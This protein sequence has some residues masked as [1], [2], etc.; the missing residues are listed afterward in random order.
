MNTQSDQTHQTASQFVQYLN[1]SRTRQHN[2]KSYTIRWDDSSNIVQVIDNSSGKVSFS[3]T[4]N[5]EAGEW[6]NTGTP[7]SE[8]IIQ[9]ALQFQ[10]PGQKNASKLIQPKSIQMSHPELSLSPQRVSEIYGGKN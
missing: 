7:L 10:S 8:E 6:Q 9:Y 2:G 5:D 4:F 3:A 1:Q